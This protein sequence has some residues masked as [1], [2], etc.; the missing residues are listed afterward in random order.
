MS[1]SW[2][3]GTSQ[4]VVMASDSSARA[5][6]DLHHCRV[7][8]LSGQMVPAQGE[9]LLQVEKCPHCSTPRGFSKSQRLKLGSQYATES[10]A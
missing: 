7:R 1:P 5:R 8:E 2:Q 6:T 4:T 3:H 9:S 10:C